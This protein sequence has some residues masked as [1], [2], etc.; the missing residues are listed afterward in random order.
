MTSHPSKNDLMAYAESLGSSASSLCAAT[1]AHVSECAY[2]RAEVDKIQTTLSAVELA[3]DIEPSRTWRASLMLAARNERRADA[4][5]A[6]RLRTR[7][8]KPVAAAAV[9]VLV[10]GGAAILLR[11]GVTQ[12]E[13]SAVSEAGPQQR[14][15]AFVSLD[16][17]RQM[18][19]EEEMLSDTVMSEQRSPRNRWE[20][21][22]RRAASAFDDDIEEALIAFQS[23]PACVRASELVNA[24]REK[25]KETL[26]ALY[27][28]RSL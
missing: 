8:Q 22:K 10:A 25:L 6:A 2:C 14:S 23:N 18:S 26:K 13:P 19:P 3:A 11:A 9:F 28:E 1:A 21:E 20:Q 7:L 12:P 16:V 24:N 17:L 5:R 27:V 4:A 15:A